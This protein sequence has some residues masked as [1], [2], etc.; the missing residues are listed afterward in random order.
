MVASSS[1]DAFKNNGQVVD[2]ETTV[3]QHSEPAGTIRYVLNSEEDKSK[4]EP[5]RLMKKVSNFDGDIGGKEELVET[6]VLIYV[7]PPH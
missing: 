2:E 7:A 4:I 6:T 3:S 1:F 5:F